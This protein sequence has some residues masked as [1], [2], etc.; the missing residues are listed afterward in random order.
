MALALQGK[1]KLKAQ[2]RARKQAKPVYLHSH[3]ELE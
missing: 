3:K 1:T 2:Q